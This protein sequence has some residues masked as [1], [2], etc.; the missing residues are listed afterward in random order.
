MYISSKATGY[1]AFLAQTAA[2]SILEPANLHP[3]ILVNFPVT[4]AKLG[5]S[6]S[7]QTPEKINVME[8]RI[9]SPTSFQEFI[10]AQILLKLGALAQKVLIY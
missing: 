4:P 9:K 7:I 2:E 3:W 8:S 5:R 10:L 6:S 1:E